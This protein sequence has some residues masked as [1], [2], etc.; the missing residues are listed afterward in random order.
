MFKV[1][2]QNPKIHLVAEKKGALKKTFRDTMISHKTERVHF[3]CLGT[4][5]LRFRLACRLLKKPK[6]QK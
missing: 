1:E 3:F 4:Q 2:I 6:V 5:Q